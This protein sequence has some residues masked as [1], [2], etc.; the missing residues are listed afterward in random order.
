MSNRP[1]NEG[2]RIKILIVDDEEIV[3]SFARDAL[4]DGDYDIELANSGVEALKKIEREF[5]DFILT[6]IRMPECDGIELAQKAREI[7]P[8]VGII[9]MTGYANLNTAKDAIKEGAYDYIMK[10]FELNEIRQAVKSA[11]KKRQK[12]TEKTLSNELNRLSDLNQLMYTISDSRSLMRLSLG[13][14][15][16]QG[17]TRLGS[18]IF[19]ANNHNEIGVISTEDKAENSF[20]E[21]VKKYDIDYFNFDAKELNAPFMVQSIEEHPLYLRYGDEKSASLLTPAWYKKGQR[22]V[23][24]ALKRGPKL[25]GFLILGYSQDSDKIKQSELKLLGI[26]ASQIAISLENIILLEESR[27][28]YKRLKDLQDQSIQLEKMAARGQMSAEIGHE[29]NNFLGVV[30]G[31]LSLMQFHLEKKDYNELGRYLKAVLNNLDNI[32]KF[33]AGL[34]SYAGV[35]SNFSKCDIN[36]LFSNTIEYL[37]AHSHFQNIDIDLDL[38]SEK[39]EVMADTIQLQQLLYN[40]LHNAAD[41]SLDNEQ[42]ADNLI[43]VKVT[44][45]T[46]NDTLRVDVKDSGKGIEPELLKKAFS[47]RFT[48]KKSGHGFGLL[49]CK[50]IIDNHQGHLNIESVPGQGTC[51]SFEI[52]LHKSAAEPALLT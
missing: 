23:N 25:Y 22:L 35:E 14:A 21:T 46:E 15:L 42:I 43:R 51:I 39:I 50:K 31:N 29:L 24:I 34:V 30:M 32:K 38:S 1:Q 45:N 52:P 4:E 26:T 7:I 8:S 28:A 41:A 37:K 17:K 19:R 3:L 9:F 6:D 13:F 33:T 2:R 47:E 11:V 48:T 16:M 18:V 10:P 5:F 40:L 44:R 27:D 36:G 49:V 12:D 20:I